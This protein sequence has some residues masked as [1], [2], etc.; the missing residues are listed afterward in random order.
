MLTAEEV[1]AHAATNL[2]RY[3]LPRIIEF[4]AT[5]PK[6]DVGKIFAARIARRSTGINH[7]HSSAQVVI[8]IISSI[9]LITDEH[10]VIS[11]AIR[12]KRLRE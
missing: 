2:T 10:C 4:R 8:S 3:K 7:I 12:C 11:F 9:P 6:T 5:L 1:K